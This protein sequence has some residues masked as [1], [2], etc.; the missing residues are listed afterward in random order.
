MSALGLLAGLGRR[1]RLSVLEAL[2]MRAPL[3]PAKK[4]GGGKDKGAPGC[5]AHISVLL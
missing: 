5:A 3:P 1:T 4:A 2:P